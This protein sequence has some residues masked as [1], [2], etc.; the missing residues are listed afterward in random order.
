MFSG[1]CNTFSAVSCNLMLTPHELRAIRAFR[2]LTQA[3]L[4]AR[5]SLSVHAVA[6][7]ELGKRDLR[8][9]SMRRLCNAL[10]VQSAIYVEGFG[11]GSAPKSV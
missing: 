5:A 10:G 7:Y 1:L 9:A 11:Q 3:D 6:E 2:K 4:A 8:C